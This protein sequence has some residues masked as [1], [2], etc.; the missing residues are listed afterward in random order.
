MGAVALD[1]PGEADLLV[2]GPEAGQALLLAVGDIRLLQDIAD[3]R[4]M[5]AKFLGQ[6][7]GLLG[8]G[9][10]LTDSYAVLID[11]SLVSGQLRHFFYNQILFQ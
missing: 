3:R 5:V 7:A 8:G 2:V 6:D 9:N 1:N 4:V 11:T 10:I